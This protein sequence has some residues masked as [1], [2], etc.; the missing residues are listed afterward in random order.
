MKIA[1]I[2]AGYVGVGVSLLFADTDTVCF[3]DI[4]KEKVNALREGKSPIS[5]PKV[6]QWFSLHKDH[7][8]A[9]TH[10]RD[11][12]AYTSLVFICIPTPLIES[13]KELNTKG[14]EAI[15]TKINKLDFAKNL[16]II[17]RSTLNIDDGA[18]FSRLYPNLNLFYMPEFLREQFI[19]EDAIEPSRI[20]IGHQGNYDTAKWII[21]LFLDH[22]NHT[23]ETMVTSFEEAAAIKLF[24]NSYLAMRVA[25][26][27]EVD[28][29]AKAHHLD[30][31]TIVHGISLDPRIG[32][33]YNRVSD[34]YGGKCLPKDVVATSNELK[35]I[36]LKD[37]LI[38]AVH[39]SNE[40]RKKRSK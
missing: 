25:F 13:R 23:T 33:Y 11:A 5:N 6:K 32:D 39:A 8:E 7:I 24:S 14:I 27:N 2:G 20:V 15:L 10:L 9:S 19:L 22:A 37:N 40:K 18:K 29:L 17:I 30:S 35:K 4:D 1:I 28:S 26:F 16:Q 36:G 3:Y 12:L 31:W 34:G 38:G 21:S